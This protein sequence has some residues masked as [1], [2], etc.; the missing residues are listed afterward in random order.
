MT[1][2]L[3]CKE[4][5]VNLED[6]DGFMPLHLA[7]YNGRLDMVKLLIQHRADLGKQNKDGYKVVDLAS[8]KSHKDIVEFLKTVERTS[9][10][11]Q[12]S[13]AKKS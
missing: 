12:S 11:T 9:N 8:Q 5:N 3:E 7:A 13:P 4:I 6:K 2:L 1:C 10:L